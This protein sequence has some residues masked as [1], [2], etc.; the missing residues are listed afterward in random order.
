M[1][2]ATLGLFHEANTFSPLLAGQRLLADGNVLRGDEITDRYADSAAT[3]GGFLAANQW[4]G[5]EV[6]PLVFACLNPMGPLTGDAFETLVDEMLTSLAAGPWDGVLLALHGAAVAERV[7]DAD[8]EIAT[9][10]RQLVGPDIPIGATLDL[11]ANISQRLIAGGKL[12]LPV[13]AAPSDGSLR[14]DA[15]SLIVCHV[16]D[17]VSAT[18]GSLAKPP[19]TDCKAASS[20][21]TYQAEPEPAFVVDLTAFAMTWAKG[22]SPVLAVLPA[23]K[24]ESEAETWHVTFWGK[25]NESEDAKPISAE[26]SYQPPLDSGGALPPLDTGAAGHRCR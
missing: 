16:P 25:N 9:R 14:H 23:P 26:L 7:L 6:V 4:A 1:R 17:S 11:H 5:V 8:G 20:P 15:A 13:D 2:L 22:E 19:K 10:V 3:M 12:T 18:A 24:A 21:A